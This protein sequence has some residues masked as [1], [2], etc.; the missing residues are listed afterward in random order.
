MEF[1]STCSILA[2]RLGLVFVSVILSVQLTAALPRPSPIEIY[3][4]LDQNLSQGSDAFLAS[5]GGGNST[6]ITPRWNVW[7][8]PTYVVY[9]KP[10]FDTDVQKIIQYASESGIPFLGTGGGHGFT[11]TLGTLDDGIDIDLGFFRGVTVDAENNRMTIGGGT[12]F[13]DVYDPLYNAGKEI[14]PYG[15]LHGLILDALESVNIVTG[16]GDIVTASETENSDLFWGVR[17]AGHNL[18]IVTSATYQ[19]YDL[20]NGGEA[21]NGD[22]IFPASENATIFSIMKS[23]EGNQ[24]AELSII[25]SMA[26]SD[27][28]EDIVISVTAIYIGPEEEGKSVIQPFIDSNPLVQNVT[29]IPWNRLNRE[30]RFGADEASCVPGIN[31][32]TYGL[33]VY[34]IDVPTYV[35]VFGMY[36]DF[37]AQNPNL[38]LATFFREQFGYS[39][40]RQVPDDN[41]AYPWRDADAYLLIFF[42]W[43]D[44]SLEPITE[45]FG[46]AIRARMVELNGERG[47]QVYVNYARGDEDEKAWYSDRKLERLGKLKSTWDPKGLFSYYNPITI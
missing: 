29:M 19:V 3:N 41:T 26:Y 31:G 7:N 25:M 40:V 35:E 2:K 13:G 10:A 9:A 23:F 30:N 32:A 14:R 45:E 22:F 36:A 33:N 24:P 12:V 15:G 1:P 11:S 16:S 20:S 18:G 46:Q 27:E 44:P 6:Q 21:L 34:D 42:A 38:R 8:P 5:A 43:S 37:Y 4:Y 39:A 47:M 28:Y 17:G